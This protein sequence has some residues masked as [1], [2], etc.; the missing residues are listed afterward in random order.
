MCAIPSSLIDR[1]KSSAPLG[2]NLSSYYNRLV[3]HPSKHILVT[4]GA[5]YIGSHTARVLLERGYDVTVVDDL[6]RGYRHNVAPEH[7]R[8]MNVG[9]TEGL[10]KLM[11]ERQVDAVV[12]FAAYIA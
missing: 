12:H 6:S 5:G 10:V 1:T 7:L 9:D 11:G 3:S 4:G 8:V 2:M